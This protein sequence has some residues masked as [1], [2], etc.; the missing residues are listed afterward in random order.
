MPST[1]KYQVNSPTSSTRYNAPS[2]YWIVPNN[3]T[4][5][6]VEV[7]SFN[8]SNALTSVANLT[9]AIRNIT[10]S[11]DL[12]TFNGGTASTTTLG[13]ATGAAV[14][15]TNVF[16]V[17]A[18][19]GGAIDHIQM[20]ITAYT[21]SVYSKIQVRRTGAWGGGVVPSVRR[22]GAWVTPTSVNVR[23]SSA[24]VVVG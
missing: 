24:W 14:N 3:A 10:G 16:T 19:V 2:A 21:G 20:W 4:N 1:A 11:S 13:P 15:G 22:T 5:I 7:Q 23:R 6:S 17:G 12:T 8:A 18:S 9:V